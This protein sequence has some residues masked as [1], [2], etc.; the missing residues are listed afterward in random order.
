MS[1]HR[2]KANLIACSVVVL[3]F[4]AIVIYSQVTARSIAL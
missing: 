2:L 4:I 1:R 3:I